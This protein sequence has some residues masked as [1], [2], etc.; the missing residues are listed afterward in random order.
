[1]TLKG[2]R[3]KFQGR[4]VCGPPS[5]RFSLKLRIFPSAD[6]HPFYKKMGKAPGATRQ[7][8]G[9]VSPNT[10]SRVVAGRDWWHKWTDIG[11]REGLGESRHVLRCL[12]TL[13]TR[14]LVLLN[15]RVGN[16]YHS[17][18]VMERQYFEGLL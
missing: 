9:E 2:K 5:V 8:L 15:Q 6:D 14:P 10:R 7:P 1:M 16:P 13:N 12:K 3:S 18:S 17:L 11:A 4:T